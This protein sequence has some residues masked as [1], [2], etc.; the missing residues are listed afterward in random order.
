MKLILKNCSGR[1]FDGVC[2][3]CE[4]L[5]Y[6]GFPSGDLIHYNLYKSLSSQPIIM[7]A[8]NPEATKVPDSLSRDGPILYCVIF[9]GVLASI[10]FY[11]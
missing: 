10:I 5:S 11:S 2:L 7:S 4:I 3:T 8:P 6:C 1:I 9:L